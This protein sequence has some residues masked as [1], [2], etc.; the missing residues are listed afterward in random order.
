MNWTEAQTRAIEYRDDKNI[1]VAAA[2][3]SGKTAVLVERIIRK[4]LDKT[5]PLSV[6]EMLV[7]TFTNAAAAEM[8]NKIAAA[9]ERRLKDD[10]DN[11]HLRAQT[12][13]LAGADIST[14][15]AFAKKIITNNI[16]KTDLPA[17]FSLIDENENAMLLS[18][19]L[20]DCLERYYAR[21]DKLSSFSDL[22]LGHGG[23]KND[24]NLRD[25][26][27]NIYN[28]ARSLARPERWLNEAVDKYRQVYTSGTISGSD[29]EEPYLEAVR[30]ILRQGLESYRT[31]MNIIDSSFP[32]DHK[33]TGFYTDEAARYA[34][35]AGFDSVEE[36]I[37]KK[38]AMNF[39][40]APGLTK[41]EKEDPYLVA[42]HKSIAEFRQ[43]SKDVLT[44]PLIQYSDT[45]QMS[46]GIIMLYPRVR[47]LKNIVLMLYRRHSRLKLSRGMLDFDDLEHNLIKL[48]M[49]RDGSSA[50]FCDLLGKRYKEIYVDEYQDTNN[51]QDTLFRLI[52][53]GRGNIF[54]VGDLKQSI[55]GFRNATPALFLEKYRSYGEGE[56]GTLNVLADNFRSRREVIESVNEMFENIMF[57]STAG[58]DY[59]ENE[60]LR[61]GADYPEADDETLYETEIIMSD[62]LVRDAESN[63][64]KTS[65]EKHTLEA[66]AVARKIVDLVHN[67]RLP[68]Y[69]KEKGIQRPVEFGDITVL[70]RSPSGSL[71]AFEAVFREY[72]IPTVSDSGGFLESIEIQTVLAFL[73]IIDNP[74]QDIPL[75]AVMRSPIFGFTADELAAIRAEYGKGYFW[76][77][78]LSFGESDS[79]TREFIE[80]V[81]QMREYSGYMKIHEL[82]YKICYEHDYL[83]IA[84]AMHG[85]EERCANLRLLLKTA[86]EFEQK[87]LSGLFDFMEYLGRVA[88]SGS[89]RSA[90]S[91]GGQLSAVTLMSIHKSKGLEFPVVILA[92]TAHKSSHSDPVVRSESLG[93]GLYCV[94]TERRLKYSS[95]PRDLIKYFVGRDERAEE[96]RLLY[97]AMTRAREKLII[98]C[99]NAG[100]SKKWK[101]P[102]MDGNKVTRSRIES[103]SVLRDWIV[104]GFL[105]NKNLDNLRHLM[106]TDLSEMIPTGE[107]RVKMTYL[108]IERLME[109]EVV[110][111]DVAE[112]EAEPEALIDPAALKEVL[113]Y[114]YPYEPLTRVPL[115]LSVSEMKSLLRTDRNEQE[116]EYTPRL[117]SVSDR[118]FHSAAENTA[119][120]RGTITHYVLQH[121]DPTKTRTA[122]ETIAQIDE[123]VSRGIISPKQLESVD[124]G[125]IV[126]LFESETGDI[127][128][129]AAADGRLERERDIMLYIKASEIYPELDG[130]DAEIMVQGV[131]DCVCLTDDGA[132]IIDYKT[133]KCT[134]EYAEKLAEDYRVQIECYARGI[135]EILGVP[136]KERIIYFLTPGTAVT[137]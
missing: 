134:A 71:G 53:G 12:M 8:K 35:L 48:I 44:S 84:E 25:I 115:K 50:G 66:I 113:G 57:K 2:A 135:K 127:I 41:N 32:E 76:N 106:E 78:V 97:V 58:I 65:P 85:G 42:A 9:I 82:I 100:S 24:D 77:A 17:G 102:L 99:T 72:G 79:K 7:L 54:M 125:S 38:N 11:K 4:I 75:I 105:G 30:E 62:V 34:E 37:T 51:I 131:A 80:T 13:K 28:Y 88:E 86:S 5:N 87:G 124:K 69:D 123:M 29:W 118:T 122:E 43:V 89:L 36:F 98:S 109:P 19:A 108:P 104:Y 81:A 96:M 14:V 20:D 56:G 136:V 119:A 46:R 126:K 95:L 39:K 83:A 101:R 93:I 132:V 6:D 59:D 52:S 70:F 67:Q 23:I 121:I 111:V 68:I 92:D 63:S 90:A 73:C 49:N 94:D 26:I 117:T 47:T 15:H 114:E 137:I 31:V 33:I 112:E 129:R 107:S 27:L 130:S 120:E 22:T 133:N 116:W 1:L 18:E 103:T 128:R 55:Y 61:P 16:H 110:T 91:T 60:R 45:E 10:P 64:L 74:L 3:G 40:R 21:I